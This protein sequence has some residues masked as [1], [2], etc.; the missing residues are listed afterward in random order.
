MWQDTRALL[1]ITNAWA[2]ILAP[3]ASPGASW[4]DEHRVGHQVLLLMYREKRMI[5]NQKPG[6]EWVPKFVFLR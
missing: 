5:S 1:T 2:E 4:R 6:T 3:N